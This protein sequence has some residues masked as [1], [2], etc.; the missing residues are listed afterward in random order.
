MAKKYPQIEQMLDD[1]LK[2]NKII[3]KRLLTGTVA[4]L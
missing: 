4:D 2:A 1:A 3:A